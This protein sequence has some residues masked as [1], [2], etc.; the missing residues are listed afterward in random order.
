MVTRSVG[1]KMKKL[2]LTAYLLM[3]ASQA[4]AWVLKEFTPANVSSISV[5]ID[6]KATDA[7]WTN[8]SEVKRYAED[9]LELSGFNVVR[10]S[11]GTRTSGSH[12]V[13]FLQV[14][15]Y[16]H[17]DLCYGNV[18]IMLYTPAKVNEMFAPLMVGNGSAVFQGYE[19]VNQLS[20]KQV[21]VFMDEIQ[22]PS[23]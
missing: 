7:C 15:A 6:D 5:T 19:K 8:I 17:Q 3:F 21:E 12:F 18:D 13:F 20:L 23:G 14:H 10:G 9:K 1:T 4:S 2:C 22:N 16:R 11:D